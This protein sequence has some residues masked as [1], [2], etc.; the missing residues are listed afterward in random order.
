MCS[1]I[2][3]TPGLLVQFVLAVQNLYIQQRSLT[4]PI[5]VQC[6]YLY[7]MHA[8]NVLAVFVFIGSL[9][10]QLFFFYVSVVLSYAVFPVVVAMV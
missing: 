1:G 5:I 3:E 10:S 4:K 2:A 9:F 8:L 7:Q 6:R